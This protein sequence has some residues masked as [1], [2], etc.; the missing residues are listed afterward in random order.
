VHTPPKPTLAGFLV[1]LRDTA[2][3]TTAELPDDD[4]QIQYSYGVSV[5]TV[6]CAIHVVSP[7]IYMLAVYNLGTDLLI[8]WANDQPGQTY[9]T[10]LRSQFGVNDFV[11]GV[12][13]STAD[14]STSES[15]TVPDAFSGLTIGQLQN[16]KT[17]YGRQYL[18][19]AQMYGTNWGLS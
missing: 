13:A 15:L 4:I 8:N 7:L 17:P 3:I 6:L 19:W 2:G 18:A 11:A 14:E 1:F 5:A 12:V 10:D 16:L 9:F